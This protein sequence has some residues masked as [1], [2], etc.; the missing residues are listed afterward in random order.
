MCARYIHSTESVFDIRDYEAA[1]ALLYQ[2]VTQLDEEQI[3]LLQ[4]S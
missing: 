2:S 1:R 3:E 4:Y